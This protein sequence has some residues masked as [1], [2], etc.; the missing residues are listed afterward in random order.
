MA[1]TKI[2]ELP[3]AT[4]PLTGTELVPVVQSGATV[5]TTLAT[6]PY[7][8]TGTGAVT[9]TVQAKLRESVSFEDFGAV[10]DGTTNDTVAIGK[11]FDYAIST[12]VAIS[13]G[14]KT[15]L[16]TAGVLEK[17]GTISISGA[18]AKSIFK[19]LGNNSTS[20][21]KFTN[22]HGGRLEN[23]KIQGGAV[24]R[25]SNGMGLWVNTC[26]NLLISG[27]E[28]EQVSAAG[29]FNAGCTDTTID[30]KSVV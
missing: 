23:F 26:Q 25:L 9:T 20:I 3:A 1:G 2:S 10:G 18:G 11:A 24:T 28:I 16:V 5:Q 8:P 12:G 22:N 6:M 4:L 30:R 19:T 15:Y 27:L 14:A 17:T 13:M 21:I 7:V 29:I